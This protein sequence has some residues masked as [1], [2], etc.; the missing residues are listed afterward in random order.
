MFS[1]IIY[2]NLD[3]RT[4]RNESVLH[5]IEKIGFDGPVERVS[6]TDGS[7]MSFDIIKNNFTD[8]SIKEAYTK[9]KNVG[10]AKM[11]LG[12]MG[13]A[14]T[15][16]IVLNKI[17]NDN[18]HEYTLILEDDVKFVDDFL[19]KCNDLIDNIPN[20]DILYPGYHNY[21]GQDRENYT[22]MNRVWGTH[23]F[24]VN[25]KAAREILKIYPLDQQ[26]D[27][28]LGRSYKKLNV[29]GTK[30]NEK[31]TWTPNDESDIQNMIEGFDNLIDNFEFIF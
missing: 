20:Y 31:L 23:S 17:I 28:E 3:R 5:E 21:D 15:Y 11:T 22:I 27:S 24:I 4:D 16:K 19:E 18:D 7:K 12:A 6:A 13:L 30:F 9:E 25:K 2:I 29:F 26:F 10:G 14:L 1:K 8:R